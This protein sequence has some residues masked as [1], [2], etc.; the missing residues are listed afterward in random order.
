MTYKR[1]RQWRSPQK[2]WRSPQQKFERSYNGRKETIIRMIMAINKLPNT[3]FGLY[4][5]HEGK[6]VKF[7]PDETFS[8]DIGVTIQTHESFGPSYTA[9]IPAPLFRESSASE[10]SK[11]LCLINLTDDIFGDDA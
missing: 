9:T 10:L 3:R 6:W 2:T 1:S 7:E 11:P 8:S 4:G 5:E